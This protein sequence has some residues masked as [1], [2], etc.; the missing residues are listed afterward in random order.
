M[1]SVPL[2]ESLTADTYSAPRSVLVIFSLIGLI[3]IAFP[4]TLTTW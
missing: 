2:N 1:T 4:E 3:S